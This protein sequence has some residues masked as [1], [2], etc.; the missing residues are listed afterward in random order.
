MNIF[1]FAYG[2][3]LNGPYFIKT[4][5]RPNSMAKGEGNFLNT[6]YSKDLHTVIQKETESDIQLPPYGCRICHL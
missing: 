1:L 3:L 2:K 4:S 5:L 6:R